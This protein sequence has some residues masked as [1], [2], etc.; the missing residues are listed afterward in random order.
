M[1]SRV[2]KNQALYT[3]IASDTESKVES[4]DLSHFANR[5]NAIDEQFGKMDVASETTEPNHARNLQERFVQEKKA[6]ES[7]FSSAIEL[8][9][10]KEIETV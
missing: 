7:P 9:K 2:R 3:Q 1:R 4:S 6:D 5:L 8:E 10:T